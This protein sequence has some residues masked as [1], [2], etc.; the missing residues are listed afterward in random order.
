MLNL[1][2]V[3]T[4][5]QE[6]GL[7]VGRREYKNQA[8]EVKES[9]PVLCNA[10]VKDKLLAIADTVEGVFQGNDGVWQL[11]KFIDKKSGTQRLSF[12]LTASKGTM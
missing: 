1:P 10:E 9:F 2:D 3:N 6:N 11:S 7:F 8:G 5:V 4:F 12:N